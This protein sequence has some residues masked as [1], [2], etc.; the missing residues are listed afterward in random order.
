MH[1]ITGIIIPAKWDENGNVI[2]VTIQTS[3]ERVYLV[4]HNAKGTE[5]LSLLHKK[6]RATGKVKKR[7]RGDF[8]ISV[9]EYQK[10]R[11]YFAKNMT[12]P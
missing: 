9:Q 3:D 12:L 2:G 6:V 4:D 1:V 11:E 7:F 8:L 5:L 10:V